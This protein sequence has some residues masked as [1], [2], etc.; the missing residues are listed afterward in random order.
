ML[1]FVRES[2]QSAM[3]ERSDSESSDDHEDCGQKNFDFFFGPK[4]AMAQEED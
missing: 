4:H 2:T 1:E 3:R